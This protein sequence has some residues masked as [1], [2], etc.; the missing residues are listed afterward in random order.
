MEIVGQLT[1]GVVH[2]FN[3]ILTVIIGMIEYCRSPSQAGR[4]SPPLQR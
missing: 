4:N 2:D 1:G 3:N